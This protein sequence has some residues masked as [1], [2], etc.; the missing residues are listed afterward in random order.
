MA[1]LVT[2]DLAT[3]KPPNRTFFD[4]PFKTPVTQMGRIA[5]V[6]YRFKWTFGHRFIG[7]NSW[8]WK[9]KKRLG[10]QRW[11][12]SNV[13]GWPGLLLWRLG[14]KIPFT[15]SVGGATYEVKNDPEKLELSRQ[16]RK[17]HHPFPFEEE[18]R[19][20]NS[21]IFRVRFGG[22]DLQFAYLRD[23][24]G[25]MVILTE[26]FVY[27][28]FAGLDVA[29]Q[30]VIDVGSSV[31]DTPAY[32]AVRGAKKVIA[33][34]PYPATYERAKQNISANGLDET[35]M[36]LNEG[37][38]ASGWM[39]LSRADMNLWANAMP[40]ADGE[41]VKFNSL[42]ELIERFKIDNAVLK[43][44]GEG[45]EYEFFGD[46]SFEDLRRF[47]QIAMKYHYGGKPIIRKLE[48]AGFEIVRKWDLHF[49]Y[50][51]SSSSPR[52]E[53]GLVLAKRLDAPPKA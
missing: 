35:V 31:G 1:S 15:A 42:R 33:F 18:V 41:A 38:G 53:A 25:P 22:R 19:G 21:G 32:F 12:I 5:S 3:Q 24:F 48:K 4:S 16:L 40:S 10:Y 52:Y 45:S 37:G 51:I 2:E 36:L 6:A 20:E 47:S 14:V 46:A 50:N 7:E 43:Y 39:K 26:C 29:G 44:H 11:V 27:E 9:A 17:T 8:A 34:E 49:S 23:R 30:V 28:Y 13:H